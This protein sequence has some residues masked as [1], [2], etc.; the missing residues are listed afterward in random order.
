[1]QSNLHVVILAAGQGT[2]MKSALPKVLHAIGGKPLLEHVIQ[3]A[4]KLNAKSLHVVY[5]HGGELVKQQ[6]SHYDVNWVLQ[7]QQHGTGHAV[8]QAMPSVPDNESV[9]ILYGDVPLIKQET[10]SWL[11][12]ASEQGALGLLTANLPTPTGYGRI[13]RNNAR[14]VVKIVGKRRQ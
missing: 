11:I 12:A 7:D 5:G 2:R 9:L 6:L 13:V 10:L 3:T 1:M 4:M 14:D 8:E